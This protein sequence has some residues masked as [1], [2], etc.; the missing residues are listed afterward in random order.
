MAIGLR[1][2]KESFGYRGVEACRGEV[3][4]GRPR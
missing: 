1:R 4:A 2:I 3:K